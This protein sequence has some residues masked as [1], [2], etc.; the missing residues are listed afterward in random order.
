MLQ[1]NEEN[2]T[3]CFKKQL[4]SEFLFINKEGGGS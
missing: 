1:Q 2:L 3:F 4:L